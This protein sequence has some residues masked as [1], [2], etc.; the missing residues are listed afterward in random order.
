ME[1]VASRVVLR[2]GDWLWFWRRSSIDSTTDPTCQVCGEARHTM[3][4]WLWDCPASSPARMEIFGRHDLN[5]DVLAT[6]PRRD[7]ALARVHSRSL[8]AL[9]AIVSNNSSG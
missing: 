8:S 2:S 1:T 3:E 7:I 6:S 5:L 9:C 4:D